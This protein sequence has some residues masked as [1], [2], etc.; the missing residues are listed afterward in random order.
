MNISIF[1][2]GYVGAV[3]LACLARNGHRVI[4]VDVDPAK[5]R[6]IAEGKSPVIEEGMLE[7]ISEVVRRGSVK[8]TLDAREA[9]LASDLS[10]ICVA[11]PA[12]QNGSQ[13]RR[14]VLTLTEQLGSVLAEKPGYHLL[15]YRSTLA[16]GTMEETLIPLLEQT[17]GKKEG[18]DFEVCFQPEFTREG[19]SIQDFDHPPFTVV[20]TR[21]ARAAD[22]LREIFGQLP[23][24]FRVT[25]IR[26]AE[27]VKYCCNN[28]HA[29]KIVFANE[30]GRLCEAVGCDP[31]EVMSLFCLD[32]QL[33]VS[34]AYLKP[35]FA[36]GGSC[37]P[38]DLRGILHMAKM[39]DTE[40]PMLGSLL[41]SNR[42]HIQHAANKILNSGKRKIGMIGLSFK[43][44]TD[45]LRESPLVLLAEY[46]LGKGLQLSIYDPEVQL[47]A[48]IGANRSYIEG[49]IPHLGN[50]M[51]PTCEQ[52]V[53]CADLVV[54]GILDPAILACLRTHLRPNQ[55]LL[56]LVRVPDR[57]AIAAQY[58]GLCW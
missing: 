16:P 28:F 25:T 12:A 35:G 7:L 21:S 5:L 55:I 32:T 44:G 3:S 4:G 36:F 11:T 2:L 43:S 13:D 49:V 42:I 57:Q 22:M 23:C 34:P 40:L 46:L 1:G 20:G 54:L 15:V 14:A 58:H 30:V 8:V 39:H 17:S 29:L 6:L 51:T 50:L 10:M 48:L 38:K 26:T 37:L 24:H 33:N 31:L 41:P 53:E 56:D 9:V 27:M 19:K 52:V 18:V 47:S 45:D